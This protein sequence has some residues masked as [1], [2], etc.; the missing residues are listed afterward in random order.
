M[1]TL[2]VT[3]VFTDEYK[4]KFTVVQP[5][6]TDDNGDPKM[7]VDEWVKERGLMWFD[8]QYENG[9]EKDAK[10]KAIIVPG[11]VSVEAI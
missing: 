4:D 11:S 5:V 2:K 8:E 10:D 6:P 7:T 1:A 9:V 3:Y